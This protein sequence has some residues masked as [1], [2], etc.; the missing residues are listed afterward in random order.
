MK[1]KEKEKDL[2][3]VVKDLASLKLQLEAKD[4]EHKQALFRLSQSESAVEELLA[5]IMSSGF[6]KDVYLSECRAHKARAEELE[7][8]MKDMSSDHTLESARIREQLSCALAELRA[9]QGEIFSLETEVVA[10]RDAKV[11][12]L[13]RVEM[14]ESALNAE[15]FKS[16]ELSRNLESVENLEKTVLEKNEVIAELELQ[17]EKASKGIANDSAMEVKKLESELELQER[18]NW[19]QSGYISL[20]ETEI[21]QLKQ[22]VSKCNEEDSK[23]QEEIALLKAELHRQKSKTAEAEAA[24][25]RA[26][27]DKLSLNLVLEQLALESRVHDKMAEERRR[28]EQEL[29]GVKRKLESAMQKVGEFRTRAEQAIS[30]AEAAEKAKAT[31]ESRI[32]RWRELKEKKKQAIAAL[33]EDSIYRD[34]M[35]NKF[36][37]DSPVKSP[38]NVQPLGKVLNM[39]F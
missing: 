15:R 34:K 11:E 36:E 28:E 24:E 32:V 17:V 19:D 16:E 13:R 35:N 12:A 5:Q 25:A 2:E 4:S 22:E 30:R 38:T 31:L 39:E 10:A 7:L 18:K 3:T 33:R 1:E 8:K 37:Y 9:A 21:K 27:S 29:E 14:V 20:L 26:I 6:E 23:A